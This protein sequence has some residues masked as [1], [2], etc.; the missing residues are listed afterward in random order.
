LPLLRT[1]TLFNRGFVSP[2][3]ERRCVGCLN[4]ALESMN[5]LTTKEVT[6]MLTCIFGTCEKEQPR[7]AKPSSKSAERKSLGCRKRAKDVGLANPKCD[8]RTHGPKF[9]PS[10]ASQVPAARIAMRRFPHHMVLC[11][12][13]SVPGNPTPSPL[14]TTPSFHPHPPIRTDLPIRGQKL[15]QLQ[16]HFHQLGGSSAVKVG[17]RYI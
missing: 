14:P 11:P 1:Y 15:L 6:R 16:K 8:P 10:L 9:E 7:E 4:K 12:L 17:C 13:R 3:C 5:M 2:M